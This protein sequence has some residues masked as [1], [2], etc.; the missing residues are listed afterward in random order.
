M[1]RLAVTTFLL[2]L[3]PLLLFGGHQAPGCLNQETARVLLYARRPTEVRRYFQTRGAA[4]SG[5]PAG[6]A[7]PRH[8]QPRLSTAMTPA[9]SP[10][11]SPCG[12]QA[13]QA[14]AQPASPSP[15]PQ[16]EPSEDT[17]APPAAKKAKAQEGREAGEDLDCSTRLGAAARVP[18]LSGFG[19]A[20]TR[21][22]KGAGRRLSIG[23]SKTATA[24]ARRA[25]ACSSSSPNA[26]M[27]TT[28]GS[29]W[30]MA[31]ADRCVEPV[32][33]GHAHVRQDEVE[34]TGAPP[35][36]QRAT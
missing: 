2:A 36:N 6:P 21:T 25:R 16:P 20:R 15:P 28:G 13:S 27:K 3:A 12:L 5:R 14:R 7:G 17:S 18:S 33:A 1:T 35:G 19:P 4:S 32:P 26:V 29:D 11:G 24:P 22:R 10:P 30:T 8:V 31:K 34:D 23:L 9:P